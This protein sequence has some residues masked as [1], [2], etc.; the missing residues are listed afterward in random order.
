MKTIKKLYLFI[1]LSFF[2]CVLTIFATPNGAKADAGGYT[3]T[4]YDIKI[5]VKENNVYG[6][7]WS[8]KDDYHASPI[9]SRYSISKNSIRKL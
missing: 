9:W 3:I 8:R 1:F 5:D 2:M 6:A 7:K 4:N